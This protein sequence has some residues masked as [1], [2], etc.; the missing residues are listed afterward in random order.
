MLFAA[1]TPAPQGFA[2]LDLPACTWKIAWVQG[3]ENAPEIY[4]QE[5]ACR[6]ALA[7]AGYPARE[8]GLRCVM[9][10]Y[11]CPGFTTPDDEGNVILDLCF[12]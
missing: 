2:A 10:R 12:T 9:E 8:T 3:P 5:A 6:A 4:G 11:Q 1:D 7:Q